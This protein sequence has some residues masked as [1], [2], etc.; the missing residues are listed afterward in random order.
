MNTET[1][2]RTDVLR[3]ML[4]AKATIE[5]TA[6][7]SRKTTAILAVAAFAL[8]GGLTGGAISAAALTDSS[9]SPDQQRALA[10]QAVASLPAGGELRGDS[11]VSSGNGDA[12]VT[13]PRKVR[14]AN[15]LIV[16]FWCLDT[17]RYTVASDRSAV[18]G[19]TCSTDPDRPLNLSRPAAF[20]AKFAATGTHRITIRTS[21]G[22]R[23][24]VLVSWATVPGIP[25][26]SAQQEAEIADGT[27]TRQEYL[28][29]FSRYQ[30]CLAEAGFPS[31][32]VLDSS[33]EFDTSNSS[34]ATETVDRCYTRELV[35]VDT[36]WQDENPAVAQGFNPTIMRFCLTSIGQ[37]PAATAQGMLDQLTVLDINPVDCSPMPKD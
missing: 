22:S 19:G 33:T 34:A 27:V 26:P 37:T 6:R 30:G 20:R 17:A 2:D 12:S 13:V 31:T 10:V 36:I 8:A 23:W 11:T 32:R 14:G 5:G 3:R 16:S 9:P 35:G 15:A 28:D 4:V 21:S 24:S 1:N 7:R 18:Y 25:R 29:A